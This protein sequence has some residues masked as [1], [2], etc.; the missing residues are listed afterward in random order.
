VAVL[1]ALKAPFPW[2]GSKA[3]V[4][5]AVWERFGDPGHYIEPFC[6]SAA[7]LLARPN[8]RP[9]ALET[10]NDLDGL[11]VNAYR[12]IRSA[13]EE[14][15][16]WVAWPISAT[17]MIA[18]Q[19]WLVARR[20]TL[21]GH[22]EADPCWYDAQ[23]AGWW[24]WGL[25][26]WVGEAWCSGRGTWAIERASEG[27]VMAHHDSAVDGGVLRR[28]VHLTGPQ[29]VKRP[30]GGNL[31]A[32]FQGLAERLADVRIAC[33]NWDRVLSERNVHV[34]HVDRSPVAVFL[35]PPYETPTR[36]P[37]LYAH[38]GAGLAKR[39]REWCSQAPPDW[40]VALCGL[41]GEHD[42]LAEA[43]WEAMTWDDDTD[44]WGQRGDGSNRAKEVVWFSPSCM[45]PGQARLF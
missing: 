20:Q 5:D 10:V 29:G 8:W 35:D 14:V 42:E 32:W 43:G 7:V 26:C 18:R 34:D 9:G 28:P 19:A 23:A 21:V 41:A 31:V 4:A 37:R 13:P 45:G 40:R 36:Y 15:A 6:G 3:P 39:V 22:L 12:A 24:L 1:K 44:G 16:E 2:Y 38:D 25:A 27:A 33:G 30:P 17:D 11:L